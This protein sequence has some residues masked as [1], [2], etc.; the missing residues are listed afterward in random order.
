MT[1]MVLSSWTLP[2]WKNDAIVTEGI[3]ESPP[4]RVGKE[5]DTINGGDNFE[6]GLGVGGEPLLT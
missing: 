2:Q 1:R 6:G 5:V 3:I 4:E